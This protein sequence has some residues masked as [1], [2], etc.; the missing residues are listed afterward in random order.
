MAFALAQFPQQVAFG[1]GLGAIYAL[2][3]IGFSLIYRSTGLLSFVHPQYVMLG[4]VFGYSFL[5]KLAL[6]LPAAVVLVALVTGIASV[7]VDQLGI[8]P[9]RYRRGTEITMILATIGWGIL[10][11]EI[12]RLTYGS[13]ALSLS[14][15]T[16]HKPFSVFGVTI[17]WQTVAVL[18]TA[19]V[20]TGAFS[21]FL[22]LTRTGRAMR[23]VG[24]NPKV[25]SLMGINVERTLALSAFISGILGGVAGLYVG[26]IFVGGIT[27]GN[28]GI[29]GLA[30]AVLG[31][32]GNLPGALL[33]GFLFGLFDN[34]VAVYVSASWR[35][36]IVFA[37][38]IVV[39]LVLPSGLLGRRRYV[40]A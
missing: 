2:V 25:A 19:A 4:S 15:A 12:V 1:L 33:G 20:F 22:R 31:G 11:V 34:L 37:L 29:K 27:A 3:A 28:I 39:L 6:P 13:D 9:I 7:I 17:Q 30:A 36:A 18:A 23:A 21:L 32:F 5:V 24:E 10:L 14:G 8:R 38:M 26:Y 35:D 40:R 16:V